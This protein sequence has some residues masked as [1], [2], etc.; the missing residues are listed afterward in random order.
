M[1]SS[2]K[3]ITVT[4]ADGSG[5]ACRMQIKADATVEDLAARYGRFRARASEAD[6][7]ADPPRFRLHRD[8]GE[9]LKPTLAA[10]ALE[11]ELLMAVAVAAYGA[12]VPEPDVEEYDDVDPL[13][14]D[15]GRHPLRGDAPVAGR[16]PARPQGGR[17]RAR[18]HVARHPDAAV[19]AAGRDQRRVLLRELVDER[20]KMIE[21]VD[22]AKFWDDREG[23][24]GDKDGPTFREATK[25][26]SVAR[27]VALCVDG[28]DEATHTP[29]EAGL[30]ARGVPWPEKRDDAGHWAMLGYGHAAAAI[31]AS[32]LAPGVY[33][34]RPPPGP[35]DEL[36][37][38]DGTEAWLVD[39]AA[40][41]LEY[42][43]K[44]AFRD[45]VKKSGFMIL[46]GV[47]DG[48]HVAVLEQR[49]IFKRRPVPAWAPVASPEAMRQLWATKNIDDGDKLGGKSRLDALPTRPPDALGDS[50]RL[51]PGERAARET[52]DTKADAP[53]P[54]RRRALRCFLALDYPGQLELVVLDDESE[55]ERSLEFWKVASGRDRRVR[56]ACCPARSSLGHKRNVGAREALGSVLLHF[57][58]D[59]VYGPGYARTLVAPVAFGGYQVAKLSAWLVWDAHSGSAGYVDLDE[60]ALTDARACPAMLAPL[61]RKGRDSYGFNFCYAA[62][63]ARKLPFPEIGFG[64]DAAFIA[65]ALRAKH[66]VAYVRDGA[67]AVL[68]V[69]HG[70]NAS[71][72]IALSSCGEPFLRASP[73]WPSLGG[74]DLAATGG[75]ARADGKA[76]HENRG[77]FVFDTERLAARGDDDGAMVSLLSWVQSDAGFAPN[78]KEKLGLA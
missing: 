31:T 46:G 3:K 78:R 48:D 30:Q 39:A 59:D 77:L 15:D 16:G 14:D 4:I 55:D 51:F 7:D 75:A 44:G 1:A 70:E 2:S 8:D 62:S 54:P 11:G 17:A 24:G 64:E 21:V 40:P 35:D 32:L 12:P 65:N 10:S 33:V 60:R 52:A 68:H 28:F 9:A 26:V 42:H 67:A 22:L 37:L 66:R 50:L 13:A 43:A 6:D 27:A 45:V 19:A 74:A 63:L 69:Q 36:V 5:K 73:L 25:Q 57:D 71:R 56:Y 18:V 34:E 47:R 29:R 23:L 72:S 58:D 53:A 38:D 41:L 61:L 20:V 76:G 49:S